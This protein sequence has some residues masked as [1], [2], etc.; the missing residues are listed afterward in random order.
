MSPWLKS[1]LWSAALPVRA[2]GQFAPST[3]ANKG[4]SS[5]GLR[6]SKLDSRRAQTHG[7]AC[8]MAGRARAPVRSE[9]LKEGALLVDRPVD[10]QGSNDAG[11]IEGELQGP[12]SLRRAGPRAQ[13]RQSAVPAIASAVSAAR[14]PGEAGRIGAFGWQMPRL[15]MR[16]ISCMDGG[17]GPY[18]E[19]RNRR[20]KRDTGCCGAAAHR[21]RHIAGDVWWL[22]V[23][24]SFSIRHA[25]SPAWSSCMEIE[26]P[27]IADQGPERD[28]RHQESAAVRLALQ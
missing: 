8:D 23:A 7:L 10:V 17:G 1:K 6:K 11:A 2:F 24:A 26:P 13:R 28:R 14:A 19:D 16:L 4:S 9:A 25:G 21:A 22:R 3:A 5:P 20:T 18:A 12:V 15:I 27:V